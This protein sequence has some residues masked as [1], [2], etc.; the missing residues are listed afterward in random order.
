MQSFWVLAVKGTSWHRN[1]F[2][3]LQCPEFL[4]GFH[5]ISTID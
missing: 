3:E 4:S 1:V 5:Y 2:V